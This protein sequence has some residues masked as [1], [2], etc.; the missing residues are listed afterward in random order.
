MGPRPL[1]SARDVTRLHLSKSVCPY[2]ASITGPAYVT[3]GFDLSWRAHI[4]TL[5]ASLFQASLSQARVRRASAERIA[6][7][8]MPRS[9]TAPLKRAAQAP[10]E[11][12]KE[13]QII[14][15]IRW[16]RAANGRSATDAINTGKFPLVVSATA[17]TKQMEQRHSDGS[18]VARK[19]TE[20]LTEGERAELKQTYI[21]AGYTGDLPG[22]AHQLL[23]EGVVSI[24]NRRPQS[25][26]I[27]WT[28]VELGKVGPQASHE[29]FQK[30]RKQE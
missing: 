18:R 9:S 6:G 2:T 15:A 3:L 1:R 25:V 7:V 20:L 27:V 21:S 16:V 24:L 19:Q 17:L 11:E 23:A 29:P 12:E 5:R 8:I 10:G 13:R 22:P 26:G 30:R 14:C 4:G 28:K